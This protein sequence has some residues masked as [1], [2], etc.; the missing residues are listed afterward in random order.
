MPM[1]SRKPQRKRRIR[2]AKRRLR[3]THASACKSKPF[4]KKRIKG[5][6]HHLGLTS[7]GLNADRKPTETRHALQVELALARP[8]A[9]L[10]RCHLLVWKIACPPT[11]TNSD[12]TIGFCIRFNIAASPPR[13]IRRNFADIQ[14]TCVIVSTSLISPT[15]GASQDLV[16]ISPTL[17]RHLLDL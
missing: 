15:R 9:M 2:L 14:S 7:T 1:G 4:R 12:K 3:L 17:S 16:D 8:C 10:L 6:R 11:N 13:G 5:L